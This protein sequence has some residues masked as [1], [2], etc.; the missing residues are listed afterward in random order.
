MFGIAVAVWLGL[1]LVGF[2]LNGSI[3]SSPAY[4]P[5]EVCTSVEDRFGGIS[6]KCWVP[7]NSGGDDYQEPSYTY[8]NC[9]EA[10]SSDD[11]PLYRGD[12]GYGDHLDRDGDGVACEPW[13]GN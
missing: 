9:D 8:I 1:S 10:R 12:P 3:N 5:D 4:N 6:E 11:A 13:Y 2:L 7:E